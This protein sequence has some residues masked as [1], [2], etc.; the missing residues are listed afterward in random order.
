MTDQN[1][2]NNV[3]SISIEKYF[4]ENQIQIGPLVLEKKIFP[5]LVHG[6]H[7]NKTRCPTH[8]LLITFEAH[9]KSMYLAK[10]GYHRAVG[11]REEV[12]CN[13]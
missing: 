9:R 13:C 7:G 4:G 2:F 10:F 11:F 12:I 8:Y 5:D 3:Y 1:F 6:C